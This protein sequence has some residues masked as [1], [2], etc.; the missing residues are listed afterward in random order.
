MR[1][2]T[3]LIS[4]NSL[5]VSVIVDA[6]N[7]LPDELIVIEGNDLVN[8]T[9]S[10][11]VLRH[12]LQAWNAGE[13]SHK[14][15]KTPGSDVSPMVLL[16]RLLQRCPDATP[17]KGNSDLSFILD[18]D[19]RDNLRLDASTS[20]SAL[21]NREWKAATVIAGSVVEALLLWRLDQEPPAD[22]TKAVNTLVS[23]G[24]ISKSPGTNLLRWSLDPF[25]EV[26]GNLHLITANTVAQCRI[27]REF[28]NLVHPGKAQRLGVVCNRGTAH[29]AIAAME[30]VIADLER[31]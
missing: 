25:I 21:I 12:A 23:A 7:R 10:L 19:L 9:S 2:D 28:R 5:E 22:I 29:S 24:T 3:D 14:V 4:S 26:A 6:V 1:R 13:H 18:K 15:F 27:A 17:A 16:R 8:F 20:H 30:Q 11:C 31:P